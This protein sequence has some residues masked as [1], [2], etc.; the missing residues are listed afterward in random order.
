MMINTHRFRKTMATAILLFLIGSAVAAPPE[1]RDD[2][3]FF[4][5]KAVS[6]ANDRIL[7]IKQRYGT[8]PFK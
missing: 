7:Q 5:A 2:A 1:V 3:Y 6:D 8:I 4:S